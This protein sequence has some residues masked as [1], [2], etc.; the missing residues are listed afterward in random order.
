MNKNQFSTKSPFLKT[1]LYTSL[2]TTVFAS[3]GHAAR[4]NIDEW[5]HC[6]KKVDIKTTHNNYLKA[7][8]D[9][10]KLNV[11]DSKSDSTKFIIKCFGG[12]E[13]KIALKTSKGK[14][15]VA[16]GYDIKANRDRVGG[17]EKFEVYNGKQNNTYALYSHRNAYIVAEKD[18]TIQAN[19][20]RIGGWES[21]KIEP[22]GTP[23]NN[24]EG[25]GNVN[26]Q[27]DISQNNGDLGVEIKPREYIGGS[28][29]D[30]ILHIKK[31]NGS[32]AHVRTEGA[33]PY[34]WG[35]KN[36]N[37]TDSKLLNLEG[38]YTL[39]ATVVSGS[40]IG[41]VATKNVS[42][43][44]SSDNSDN[45]GNN[46]SSYINR[47]KNVDLRIACYNVKVNTPFSGSQNNA[48]SQAFGRIAKAL[49]PDIW[50]FQETR[51]G[52]STNG[53]RDAINRKLKSAT[54]D[55]W[56]TVVSGSVGLSV[57]MKSKYGSLTGDRISGSDDRAYG[58]RASYKN[59]K[60]VIANTH[61][62]P[63]ANSD[64]KSRH[65]NAMVNYL[66]SHSSRIKFAC[67][68][69]NAGAGSKAYNNLKNYSD[70]NTYEFPRSLGSNGG[71][72]D[73]THG[74]VTFPERGSGNYTKW[75]YDKNNRIDFGFF[76]SQ[77]LRLQRTFILNT[78]AMSDSDLNKSGLKRGDVINDSRQ[79]TAV[80]NKFRPSQYTHDS[81]KKNVYSHDHLPIV[82]DLEI[83]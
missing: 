27:F 10:N 36:R 35:T 70:L 29:A 75:K 9:L 11:S 8:N 40:F 19:R 25:E 16:T 33:A 68:D 62:L 2:F 65:T 67:G 12:S 51:G 13:D 59:N 46:N 42:V 74:H 44:G 32:Y 80:N 3:S 45:R 76:D 79:I 34:E 53:T 30:I 20:T 60:I 64:K 47:D 15:V 1:L 49:N 56:R 22:D 6:G 58:T 55:D 54:G 7:T 17:W 63:G 24:G 71:N 43:D 72:K 14:Y 69:L 23:T 21:F 77:K 50:V 78:L 39:K 57:S 28:S 48:R 41:K 81:Q 4:V 83:K 31:G 37:K 66:K 73:Y 18:G 61:L 26:F 82:F 52:L 5:H 38:N